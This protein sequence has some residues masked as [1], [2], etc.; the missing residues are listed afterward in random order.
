MRKNL[1]NNLLKTFA[2]PWSPLEEVGGRLFLFKI[3]IVIISLLLAITTTACR[4]NHNHAAENATEVQYTCPMH[5]QIV[6]DQPGDCPVCGMTLVAKQTA[7]TPAVTTTSDL[8]YLLQP[9]NQTIVADLKTIRPVQK[10]VQNEII[11]SG[12][13]TYD[14][15]QQFII[16]ARFSG[17]LEKLYVQFNYQPVRKGQKLFDIYSP[18]LVTAQKELLYLLQNDP[19]NT[20]LINGAR[21]K[22]KFLGATEAQLNVLAENG[23]ESYIFSVYS[24]YTGYVLDPAVTAAP[25]VVPASS[26]A[27]AGGDNMATM[28]N[29]GNTGSSA[30]AS[31]PTPTTSN[32]FAIREGMYVT[33][34]QA[35]LKVVDASQVWAQFKVPSHQTNPLL[36]GTTISIYFNQIPGDSVRTRVSLVEPVY[37]AGENFAQ[38]RASLPTKNKST[39]IGQ[40]ITGKA[41][42]NTGVALWVPKE[43]VLDIGTQAVAFQKSNNVFKPVLVQVGQRANSQV[44]IVSGLTAKDVVAANAQF[45]V[46]S[47]SFIKVEDNMQ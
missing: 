7:N 23:K 37:A 1:K 20:A 27:T 19:T 14:T 24:P 5:P 13:V 26:I 43:A 10:Q 22:L 9:V 4:K 16:P 33:T 39:Q 3:P 2:N 21:Q 46:D 44:E 25:S 6:R 18:E 42:Y 38:V 15:R 12:I 35:L 41:T 34:G 45:L 31:T 47:E 11:M 29:S 28:G 40:L 30:G 32:G 8:N 36:P 17:R